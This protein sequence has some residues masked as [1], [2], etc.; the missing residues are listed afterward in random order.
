[1]SS[2][3]EVIKK[4]I[5]TSDLINGGQLNPEQQ[6]RFITMVKDQAKLL[7]ICRVE[8]VDNGKKDLDRMW[9]GEPVT[10]KATEDTAMADA[11]KTQPVFDKVS[12][13]TVKV[14]SAYDITTETMDKNIAK[15]KLEQQVMDTVTKRI[16]TDLELLGIQG[17]TTISPSS[18]LDYLLYTLDGWD[19]QTGSAHIVDV[20]GE[21]I[22]KSVFAEMIRRMPEQ[23]LMDPDLKWFVSKTI[24]TDWL[25]T[26]ADRATAAGDDA[27]KGKGVNPYGYPIVELPLIPSN[28]T[29]SVTAATSGWAMGT[30]FGPFEIQAGVNDKLKMDV[31]NA[32]AQEITITAGVYTAAAIAT[33]INAGHASFAGVASD[34][35]YGQL[36]LQSP[37]T[38][39]TSE[40]DIQAPSAASSYTELGLTVGVNAGSDSGVADNIPEG[41]F[42]WLANPMNF[43]NAILGKTRMYSEFNKDKDRIEV[44]IYN[45]VDYKVENLDAIVKAT[46]IRKRTI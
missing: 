26:I 11:D 28:K 30:V 1:M 39:S 17:D 46:N 18:K 6:D 42:I 44:V 3:E 34:N 32:G 24:N 27:L 10:R 22:S 38:G 40:I 14:Q 2:N 41:S 7:K 15:E 37:T 29:L 9:V 25:D 16:A 43:V 36:L 13:S 5:S 8:Q 12:I 23:Y 21:Y 33:A 35:G 19:K 4:A 45:E 20:G 31:D